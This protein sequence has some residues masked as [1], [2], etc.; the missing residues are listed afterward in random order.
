MGTYYISLWHTYYIWK[1]ATVIMLQVISPK[2]HLHI[3][4]NINSHDTT[5]LDVTNIIN[6]TW[7]E[8]IVYDNTKLY[9]VQSYTFLTLFFYCNALY[10]PA[11]SYFL[12]TNSSSYL[13]FILIFLSLLLLLNDL[14][15]F[16]HYCYY[17]S[18]YFSYIFDHRSQYFYCCYYCYYSFP[19]YYHFLIFS[20][21]IFVFIFLLFVTLD[22]HVAFKCLI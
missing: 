15:Y 21:P 22:T 17:H 20:Y 5:W 2:Y 18:Y 4:C 8:H 10:C 9:V 14:S 1:F 13:T 16:H 19:S 11:S 3:L 6:M 12:T 7:D